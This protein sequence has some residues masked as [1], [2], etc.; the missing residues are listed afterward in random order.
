MRR[1]LTINRTYVRQLFQGSEKA[2][3][4]LGYVSSF[5]E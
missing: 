3:T 2:A 1:S 4:A 5:Q